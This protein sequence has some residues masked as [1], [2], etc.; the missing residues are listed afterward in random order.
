MR[1]VACHL[2]KEINGGW[3]IGIPARLH[4]IV[5]FSWCVKS[6]LGFGYNA[7]HGALTLIQGQPFTKFYDFT[8]SLTMASRD[9]DQQGLF[10]PLVL[11]F[12]CFP[13]FLSLNHKLVGCLAMFWPQASI[14][15]S[16]WWEKQMYIP[17]DGT[18]HSVVVQA[19]L[20]VGETW[21][22]PGLSWN[23]WEPIHHDPYTHHT[24]SGGQTQWQELGGSPCQQTEHNIGQGGGGLGAGMQSII[25]WPDITICHEQ[26][27]SLAARYSLTCTHLASSYRASA[28]HIYTVGTCGWH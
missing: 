4:T 20:W 7:Y 10:P 9:K 16:L 13:P 18:I 28:I 6:N 23:L 14:C 8:P 3:H 17:F 19:L 15:T 11:V 1:D 5:S 22:W 25:F 12:P 27:A 21:E 26:R 24:A 2:E